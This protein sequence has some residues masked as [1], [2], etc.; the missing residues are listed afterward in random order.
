[1]HAGHMH[2]DELAWRS[3]ALGVRGSQ[4]HSRS[5]LA[6]RRAPVQQHCCGLHHTACVAIL[7]DLYVVVGL[8]TA[9]GVSLA[10]CCLGPALLACTL[11]TITCG[12]FWFSFSLK[13]MT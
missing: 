12:G 2:P 5:Y 13:P 10:S 4:S 11:S 8:S 7:V 1:M 3:T 6:R 9:Q